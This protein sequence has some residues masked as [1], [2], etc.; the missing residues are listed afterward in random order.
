MGFKDGERGLFVPTLT[1]DGEQGTYVS[2]I[3]WF[4]FLLITCS[5]LWIRAF[6]IQMNFRE[7]EIEE[8]CINFDWKV[9][10]FIVISLL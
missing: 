5:S 6:S 3:Q 10:D 7:I 4:V 2:L 9:V 1:L 8:F